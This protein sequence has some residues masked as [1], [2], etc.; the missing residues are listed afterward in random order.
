MWL[1]DQVAVLQ[2]GRL[3][4][5]DAARIAEELEAL[6]R[7][8]F[9]KLRSALRILVM[10]MLKWDQQPE[11]RSS[12]WMYSIREQRRRYLEL[13]EESPGLKPRRDE[14]LSRSYAGARAAAALETRLSERQFP[15]HCPYGWPELLERP[16]ELDREP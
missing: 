13:I 12:S 14:A 11:L 15:A 16:F 8:E 9:A 5:I 1:Q 3:D 4:E 10:H 6:A 7:N 2:A